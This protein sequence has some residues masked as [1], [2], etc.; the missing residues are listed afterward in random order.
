MAGVVLSPMMDGTDQDTQRYGKVMPRCGNAGGG[1][2]QFLLTLVA[3]VFQLL[4][5]VLD[6]GVI[7]VDGTQA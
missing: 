7:R 5:Q 1:S 3:P 6:L 4:Q 2:G